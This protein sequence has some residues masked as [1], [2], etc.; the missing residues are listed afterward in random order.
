[1]KASRSV[2]TWNSSPFVSISFVRVD[3]G[4]PSLFV[5][6]WRYRHFAAVRVAAE[7]QVLERCSLAELIVSCLFHETCINVSIHGPAV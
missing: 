6:R 3:F 7:C 1:M 2:L 5:V 4:I